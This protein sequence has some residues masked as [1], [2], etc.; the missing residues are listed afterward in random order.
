MNEFL[1]ILWVA[2]FV[3]GAFFA[4]TEAVGRASV[5]SEESKKARMEICLSQGV[6]YPDCYRAIFNGIAFKSN[7]K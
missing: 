5:Y 3:F 7:E 6:T 1:K 2:V 4:I